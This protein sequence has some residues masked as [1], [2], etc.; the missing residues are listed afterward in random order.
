M[1]TAAPINWAR[2]LRAGVVAGLAGAIAI[3]LFLYAAMVAPRHGSMLGVWAA[4]AAT[5]MGKSALQ[6]PAAPWIG[7]F[8]HVCVSVGWACGYAYMAQTR[9]GINRNWIVS[10]VVFGIVVMVAMQIVLVAANAF[11]LPKVPEFFITLVAHTVFF[12]LPV[13]AVVRALERA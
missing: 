1:A 8:M 12:G 2:V 9:D 7:L 11:A 5:G 10:G 13:A 4:V 6:N 3:D